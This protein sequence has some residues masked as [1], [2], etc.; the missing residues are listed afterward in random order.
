LLSAALVRRYSSFSI[1]ELR[2]K[3][4]ANRWGRTSRVMD[5]RPRCVP[6]QSRRA[7]RA[8]RPTYSPARR[9]LVGFRDSERLIFGTNEPYPLPQM[10]DKLNS[11]RNIRGRPVF[12]TMDGF[13]CRRA[14]IAERVG[15][16]TRR[17]VQPRDSSGPRNQQ[18]RKDI[19]RFL[20]AVRSYPDRVAQEPRIT[21]EQ[22]LSSLFAAAKPDSRRRGRP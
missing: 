22:H 16:M 14:G 7:G 10:R 18:A 21:F 4:S 9:R 6:C 12:L 3:R 19:R 20:L 11:P 15:M 8:A 5:C 13:A 2:S 1:L 17:Y